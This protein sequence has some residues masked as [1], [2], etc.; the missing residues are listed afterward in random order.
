MRRYTYK[1]LSETYMKPSV[2]FTRTRDD[3]L[4]LTYDKNLRG[5]QK[6]TTLHLLTFIILFN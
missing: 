5:L 3:S 2:C 6:D 1:N 4:G